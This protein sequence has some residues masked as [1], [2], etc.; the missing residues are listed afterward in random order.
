MDL[1][2]ETLLAGYSL[3]C[4]SFACIIVVWDRGISTGAA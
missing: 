1:N 2:I 3:T 4:H